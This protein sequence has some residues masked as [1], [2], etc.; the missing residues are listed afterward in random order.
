MPLFRK[1]AFR[2]F[3]AGAGEVPFGI[4]GQAIKADRRG[5]N[6]EFIAVDTALNTN[7]TLRQRGLRKAPKNLKLVK[8]C[9]VAEMKKLPKASQDIVFA[10]FFLNNYCRKEGKEKWNM[11]FLEYLMDAKRALKPNGRIIIIQNHVGAENYANLAI[12]AG[13]K[14]TI[15]KLPLEM[16]ERSTAENIEKRATLMGR[17]KTVKRDVGDDFLYFQ[18]LVDFAKKHNLKDVSDGFWPAAIIIRK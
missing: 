10:S 9:A 12:Q 18:K 11:R 3:E 4:V 1:K 6:R 13:L 17:R 2:V 5:L 14:A 8:N 16:I 15:L 7:E